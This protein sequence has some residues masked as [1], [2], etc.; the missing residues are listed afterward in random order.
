[1]KP[2]QIIEASIQSADIPVPPISVRGKVTDENG[3]AVSGVTVM[4][5][6]DT[7]GTQTDAEGNYSIVDVPDNAVLVFTAIG[8]DKREV[9]IA[10]KTT[11]NV[12][13]VAK[14]ESLDETVVVAYGTQKIKD[15]TGSISHIG[16]Q[17]MKNAPMG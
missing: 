13:L 2:L 11:I 15:V 16:I 9:A 17:E 12:R 5:K 14:I 6:G 7:K 1:K 4:V 8:Y 10:K 3:A